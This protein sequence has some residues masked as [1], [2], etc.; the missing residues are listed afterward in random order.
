MPET[1]CPHPRPHGPHVL[2]PTDA[3]WPGSLAELA[4]PP[5]E[6]ALLG[7]LPELAHAV[8]I[9]GTREPD[10]EAAHFAR[11]L[12]RELAE[13]GCPIISGGA[14]GIDTAAHAGALA[15][16]GVTV[17]VL[18]TG[19]ERLYPAQNRRLFLQIAAHGALL[20]ESVDGT[21]GE[22]PSWPA[23]FLERNRLIAALA[24]VVIVVQAPE[25]SG[26]MSTAAHARQLGRPL[27]AVPYAPWLARGAGCLTLLA[28]G[29]RVCRGSTDVLSLAAP[30]RPKPS[31]QLSR[32]PRKV[33]SYPELDEDERRVV[34]ALGKTV[35]SADQL[36]DHSGLP[37][38][39]VQRA[40]LMLLLSK[41]IQEV[42]CG[43]YARTS[44][45]ERTPPR[46]PSR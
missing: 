16:G 29:A 13:A 30:E 8:A 24:R 22:A 43:R 27:L 39:R 46:W 11:E 5:V 6:L 44:V 1:P 38:P 23:A 4:R 14:R 7:Q 26:A 19:V 15:G 17:A 3:A 28:S 10:P 37:A 45:S 2:R 41:V 18:A 36:C 33:G 32:R 9:V 12:A 42:G 20:S 35:L 31:R 40:I 34:R 25:R 21:L